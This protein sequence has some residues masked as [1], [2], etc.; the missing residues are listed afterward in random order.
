VDERGVVGEPRLALQR[1]YHLSYPF[2][3]EWR[4]DVFLLP[5]TRENRTVELY[6]AERFPDRW[7][8]ERRLFE[9]VEAVDCT[10]H[11][12]DDRLWLFAGIG[13]P[14]FSCNDELHVF[15]AEDP[16]GPWRPHDRNPVVSDVCRA[17]PAGALFREGGRLLRPSQD[18]SVRYGYA[19]T[20]N[21]VEVLTPEDYR[22][23]PV[24]RIEPGWIAGNRGSHTFSRS[25]RL[26][27]IDG[28][29]VETRPRW[30]RRYLSG[31][32]R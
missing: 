24:A 18:C 2:V 32:G 27:V 7:T 25:E 9:G 29:Q 21:E 8:L 23:R 3:F 10:V 28:Q 30:S 19:I 15:H 20:F 4:G 14:T 26:E 22:E 17:R 5:E 6:R 16:R 1:P 11:V 13:K 12:A 31:L